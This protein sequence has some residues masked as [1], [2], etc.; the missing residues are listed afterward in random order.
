MLLVND[1]EFIFYFDDSE[2]DESGEEK[3]VARSGIRASLVSHWQKLERNLRDAKGG[4]ARWVWQSWEWLHSR[5]R[6]DEAMLARFRSTGRIDLHH[7]A[8]RPEN[9]VSHIWS[10]YLAEREH[11]HNGYLACNA[12]IAPFALAL[13]W[14][15]PGPNLIGYWFAYRAVHHWLVV[16]GIKVVR[17]G[18]IPTCCH[19]EPA[20]DQ[21]VTWS[22]DGKAGHKAI[23]GHASRLDEYLEPT[24]PSRPWA[25][26]ELRIVELMVPSSLSLARIGL[27]LWFPWVPAGWRG[28]VIV[29]A[30][31]SDLFDGLLSRALGATSTLGQVLDPVADKLF[32]GI[33]LVTLM[34]EGELT[35]WEL[36]LLASRYLAVLAGCG[37]SV[38]GHGWS[39]IRQMPPSWLGKIATAAQLAFLLLVC[40]GKNQTTPLYRPVEVAAAAFSL[41]AGV[42]YLWRR[43]AIR[44]NHETPEL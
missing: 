8:G 23:N 35:A 9:D 33:V 18:K 43:S 27:A 32:V 16:R 4:V 12:I 7:P 1:E 15:L 20:L 24:R 31:L 38:I 19:G 42:D 3:P 29:A 5:V 11:R 10:D 37:W 39:S 26:G 17:R 34:I 14:P 22:E 41:A 21:P 2:I 6:P 44:K 13:L 25:L 36:V 40:L 30:G 28:G